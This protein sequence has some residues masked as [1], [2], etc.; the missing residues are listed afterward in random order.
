[1]AMA[2]SSLA[3]FV[4]MLSATGCGDDTKPEDAAV[5]AGMDGALDGG[6]ADAGSDAGEIATDAGPKDASYDGAPDCPLG[7]TTDELCCPLGFASF[8]CMPRT[9]DGC[10]LPDMIVSE[11][12]LEDSALVSWQQ[13]AA[14]D[15]AVLDGCVGGTGWRRL[16]R[17]GTESANI[18]TGDLELGRPEEG[19]PHFTHSACDDQ[20]EFVGYADYRLLATDGT[21]EVGR[22]HK[23]AFCL[24]DTNRWVTDDPSVA[25]ASRYHCDFQGIQRGWSDVYSAGLDCQW[26]DVTDV[27]PGDYLLHV[28]VNPARLIPEVAYDNNEAMVPVTIPPEEAAEPLSPCPGRASGEGRDC[29]WEVAV[30]DGTCSPGT[31]MWAG[32]GAGCGLG[33]GATCGAD[34]ILRA[35]PGTEPC[36][37]R[38]ALATG[39]DEC[40][41]EAGSGGQCPKV[42]FI[43]PPSGA[44]TLLTGAYE[45]G[46]PYTC[47]ALAV[48]DPS[49]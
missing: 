45:S 24:M 8:R 10:P 31:P 22:G 41:I 38:D 33:P 29:G 36:G 35:C 4:L 47:S 6:T 43:C 34:P 48:V 23:R 28:N 25:T 7:C 14:D 1:M 3:T 17:F 39:D 37:L 30:A 2:T 26:I 16:L 18:G 44:F 20:Y 27:P 32:C 13:F 40:S 9:A 21:T 46:E 19:N 5:E 15:C 42:G 49:P 12:R 11:E